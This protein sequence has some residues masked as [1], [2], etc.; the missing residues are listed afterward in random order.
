M[1]GEEVWGQ[2]FPAPRFCDE[3]E[4]AAQRVVG[5]Q[6]LKL[7]LKRGALVVEAIR[8]QRAGSRCRRGYARSTLRW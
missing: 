6:H 4:V 2:G 1:L 8:F 7:A 5:E 3:F